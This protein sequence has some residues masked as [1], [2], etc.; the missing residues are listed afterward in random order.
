MTKR[1]QAKKKKANTSPNKLTPQQWAKYLALYAAAK[2]H[3]GGRVPY[4]WMPEF[5]RTIEDETGQHVTRQVVQW[6]YDNNW[7]PKESEE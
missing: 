4:G 3:Y 1:K 6:Q 5:L 2:S 7:P